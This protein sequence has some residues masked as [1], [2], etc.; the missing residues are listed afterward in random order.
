MLTFRK[1][2][3]VEAVIKHGSITD[4]ARAIGISQPALTQGIKS[5]EAELNITLFTRG[6]GGLVPTAFAEPFS[7]Y[8]ADI[9][10]EI[11]ATKRDLQK[12]NADNIRVLRVQSGPRTKV[13]WLD[14][15]IKLMAERRPDIHIAITVSSTALIE[16]IEAETVDI[17]LLPSDI[18]PKNSKFMIEPI[19]S[20]TNRFICRADHPLAKIKDPTLD[21]I[22][23]YPFVGN[24]IAPRHLA[25][26][27]H[28]LGKLGHFDETT[29]QFVPAIVA[30]SIAFMIECVK[31]GDCIGMLILEIIDQELENGELVAIG[32]GNYRLA[33]LPTAVVCRKE[34]AGNEDARDFINC[35]R[36]IALER[37][38]FF[39]T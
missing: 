26:F 36:E 5:I 17:S 15:A 23:N 2:E 25:Q 34:L 35:V 10:T 13:I 4:A 28:D 11:L 22:R 3:M 39:Q 9:R 7:R 20:V 30:D 27:G 8:A 29:N 12:G 31:K 33:D 37:N 1:I 21:Q 32:E 19:G 24:L 18:F 14:G 16:N 6:S 38:R